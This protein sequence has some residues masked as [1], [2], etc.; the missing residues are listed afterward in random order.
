MSDPCREAVKE[1]FQVS[2]EADAVWEKRI[3]N[4]AAIIHRIVY[5]PLLARC[6]KAEAERDRLREAVEQVGHAPTLAIATD[7]ARQAL[8]PRP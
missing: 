6:E 3:S 4:A 7:V 2:V 5:T 8:E 1:L